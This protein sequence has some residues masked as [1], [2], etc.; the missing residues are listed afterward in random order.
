MHMLGDVYLNT[1]IEVGKW[2]TEMKRNNQVIVSVQ[3]L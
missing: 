1:I 3:S 2:S